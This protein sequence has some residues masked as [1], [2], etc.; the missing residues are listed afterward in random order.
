MN[1]PTMRGHLRHCWLFTWR[2]PVAAAQAILPAPL[3]P[4]T[5]GGFAFWN[6]VVCRVEGLR[7]APLPQAM[8]LSYWHVAYR[9][10][11]RAR[12]DCGETVEGLY[13]V[14]SDSD[15]AIVSSGGNWLTDFRFHTASVEVALEA[16]AITGR[17]HSSDGSAS[18][19]L[20][21][22]PPSSL[23]SGS[24]F[25]SLSEAAEF[26]K[27]KPFALSP[28]GNDSVR[29]VRVRR[30]EANWSFRLVTVEQ[31]KWQFF[32]GRE[33]MPEICYSV[34]PIDYQWE[35]VIVRRVTA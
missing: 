12:L 29:I 15:N 26:L 35:R 11:A 28:A 18:F 23:S 16:A 10:H 13:F 5:C 19:R 6:V 9:L 21:D 3:E 32:A 1:A 22:N 27:Y 24:P 17:I 31:S 4:V 30:N 7:P 14:R 33:T 25:A 20:T 2:T 34:E 8:G